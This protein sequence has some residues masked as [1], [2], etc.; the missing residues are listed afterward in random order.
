N[1]VLRRAQYIYDPIAA[2]TGSRTPCGDDGCAVIF[3]VL[4]P[5]HA[6]LR[7][8]C[9]GRAGPFPLPGLPQPSVRHS[10]AAA[11]PIQFQFEETMMFRRIWPCLFAFVALLAVASEVS[12]QRAS[13]RF[14]P[15]GG[16]GVHARVFALGSI[17]TDI[18]RP[19]YGG[20]GLLQVGYGRASA[21]ALGLAGTGGD[22]ESLLV[23]GGLGV[24]LLTTGPFELTA[25]GGY[26]MYS[27]KGWSGIE[28]DA[29]GILA[30]ALVSARLGALR[31]ALAFSD[32]MGEYGEDDVSE[33]FSFHAPR[34]SI[35]VGF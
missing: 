14:Q 23:G 11:V 27:E 20:G 22:Y 31:V 8:R 13:R 5:R 25:F 29:G 2:R 33:P 10:W 7:T 15:D 3:S 24:R 12:A 28:R 1:A 4:W 16:I 21:L 35:G 32:L 26:G 6:R 17:G 19:H 9:P 18:D 30:G 34:I